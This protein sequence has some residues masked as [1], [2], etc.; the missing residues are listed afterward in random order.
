MVNGGFKV[1]LACRLLYVSF[2]VLG[3]VVFVL[4][5]SLCCCSP[6]FVLIFLVFVNYVH[7][8]CLCF[9][10]SEFFFLDFFI[11]ILLSKFSKFCGLLNFV[12]RTLWLQ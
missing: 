6:C 8:L 3:V 5:I 10:G 12:G 4:L 2:V 11:W 9:L 1:G 7:F